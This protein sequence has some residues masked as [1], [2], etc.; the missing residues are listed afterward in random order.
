MSP[1][2]VEI[3]R[4]PYAIFGCA[5]EEEQLAAQLLGKADSR[6]EDEITIDRTASGELTIN[7][8]RPGETTDLDRQA[9]LALEG[10]D[11]KKRR[12][13]DDRHLNP[14]TNPYI[15]LSDPD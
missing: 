14:A 4:A 6:I 11:E 7:G 9:L 5:E 3:D 8:R 1:D 10:R 13:A 12:A 2:D 15:K